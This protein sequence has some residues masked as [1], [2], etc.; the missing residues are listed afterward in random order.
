MISN[1][2]IVDGLKKIAKP[3]DSEKINTNLPKILRDLLNG[4]RNP[5]SPD[6]QSR[7]ITVSEDKHQGRYQPSEKP[8]VLKKRTYTPP[9]QIVDYTNYEQFIQAFYAWLEKHNQHR[10]INLDH[11]L[12]EKPWP[13]MTM[14]KKLVQQRTG[15]DSDVLFNPYED[16]SDG[17]QY[18]WL[19]LYWVDCNDESNE[20]PLI[21]ML[22]NILQT[23]KCPSEVE[24]HLPEAP[25][26]LAGDRAGMAEEVFAGVLASGSF[27]LMGPKWNKALKFL[28]SYDGS[29]LSYGDYSG[30]ENM[31]E[32]C[33]AEDIDTLFEYGRAVYQMRQALDP[34]FSGIDYPDNYWKCFLERIYGIEK[35]Y[36]HIRAAKKTKIKIAV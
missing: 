32:I 9:I 5:S 16:D 8:V 3:Y 35:K 33:H 1:L 31:V 30:D 13:I 26:E 36:P 27:K 17:M 6:G 19:P 20:V 21:Y 25:V 18:Y 24:F 7:D 28:K 14:F 11:K 4:S 10:K 22:E 23:I 12:V 34:L 2:K 29:S 15:Y